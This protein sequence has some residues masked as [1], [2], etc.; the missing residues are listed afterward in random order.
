MMIK[1]K[2]FLLSL[3]L[4]IS[5]NYSF[6]NFGINDGLSQVSVYTVYQDN[7]GFVWIGTED[8]LNQF[9]AYTF[10]HYFKDPRDSTTI[11]DN[12]V[13]EIISLDSDRLLIGTQRGLSIFDKNLNHFIQNPFRNYSEKNTILSLY[14]TK[15]ND[16][17]ISSYENPIVKKSYNTDSVKYYKTKENGMNFSNV[18]DIVED[19]VGNLWLATDKG[20]Y[21]YQTN[22]DRFVSISLFNEYYINDLY[23]D[24]NKLYLATYNFFVKVYDIKNNKDIS[25]NVFKQ[26]NTKNLRSLTITKIIKESE[27]KIWF[28]SEFDGLFVF[29]FKENDQFQLKHNNFE[30]NS[31]SNDYIYELYADNKQNIWIGTGRGLS[32]FDDLN[33]PFIHYSNTKRVPNFFKNNSIWEM[34]EDRSDQIWITSDGGINVFKY[35]NFKLKPINLKGLKVPDFNTVNVFEDSKKN[36]WVISYD[37]GLYL[38]NPKT[39]RT[40]NLAEKT[41]EFKSAF[42]I[43]IE[44][45]NDG[46]FWISSNGNG[47]YHYDLK[48]RKI[49]NHYTENDSNNSILSNYILVSELTDTK[50]ILW[51]GHFEGLSEFNIETGTKKIYKH[52]KNDITSLSYNIIY[53]IL[54]DRTNRLWVGTSF[55][56]NLLDRKTGEFK[57]FY[58]HDGLENEAIYAIEEDDFGNIWI[59]TNRGLSRVNS[60]N[61]SITNFTLT[62]GLQSKEFNAGSSLKLRDGRLIFG[63]INGINYFNPEEFYYRKKNSHVSLVNFYVYNHEKQLDKH[64]SKIKSINLETE[65]NVFKIEFSSFEYSGVADTRYRYKLSGFDNEWQEAANSNIASY[66]NVDPGDYNFLIKTQYENNS[67]SE[68]ISLLTINIA[69]PFWMTLWFKSLILICLIL[70]LYFGYRYRYRIMYVRKELLEK[71]VRERTEELVNALEELKSTQNQLIQAEKLS[72]LGQ[73]LAG[74]AHEMNTPLAYIMNNVFLSKRIISNL[75]LDISEEEFKSIKERL[76]KLLSQSND[77]TVILRDLISELKTFSRTDS[78]VKIKTSLNEI[79]DKSLQLVRS[80]TKDSEIIIETQ[81]EPDI[82]MLCHPNQIGQIFVNLINNACQAMEEYRKSSQDEKISVMKITVSTQEDKI[83]IIVTDN[84]GGINDEVKDKIF[85]PFFTTKNVGEGTGLGLSI[86]Y[87]IVKQHKGDI[88]VETIKDQGTTFKIIFNKA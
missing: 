30:K 80:H 12:S 48:E 75:K 43:D 19:S 52:D 6:S 9:D 53:S 8:G 26:F 51:T 41:K 82:Y 24:G 50:K 46:T 81:I 77:G 2:L 44:E 59:S 61:F 70:I 64:I 58:K 42:L 40:E 36:V 16:V 7:S 35:E 56:L 47:L 45:G 1:F 14:N 85:D 65:E 60:K 66:M 55:G 27:S 62:D 22:L 5:Q 83:H 79:I 84:G 78:D 25:E 57:K 67:W 37:K 71:T 73:M 68:E 28:G 11:N 72:S 87:N 88:F 13:T 38:Y 54:L 34:F 21:Q 17:W 4:L 74:I 86:T 18:N 32:L 33:M 63:G 29:D 15:K 49:L 76:V 23:M 10:K 31:L 3:Y 20:L 69:S 39:K